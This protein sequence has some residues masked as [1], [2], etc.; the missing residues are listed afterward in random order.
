MN[1]RRKKQEGKHSLPKR[2]CL[3]RDILPGE[4][5]KTAPVV[6]DLRVLR[7]Q[8]GITLKLAAGQMSLWPSALSRIERGLSRTDVLA[9]EY[10][11][12]LGDQRVAL[13]EASSR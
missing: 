1:R 5:P 7:R 9:D 3:T 13:D 12:W 6:I 11:I 8:L 2:L 10:R 4:N